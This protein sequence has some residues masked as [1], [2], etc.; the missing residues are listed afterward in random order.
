MRLCLNPGVAKELVNNPRKGKAFPHS[1][2]AKPD[3]LY[4]DVFNVS[5]AHLNPRSVVKLLDLSENAVGVGFSGDGAVETV[6]YRSGDEFAVDD[7]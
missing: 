1:T 7:L 5:S 2:R 4:S 3:L 6:V